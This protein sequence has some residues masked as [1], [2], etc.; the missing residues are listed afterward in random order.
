MFFSVY[1]KVQL[2]KIRIQAIFTYIFTSE[3]KAAG[4]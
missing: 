2:S 4:L 3:N 1:I